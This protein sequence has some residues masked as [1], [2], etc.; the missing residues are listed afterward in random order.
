MLLLIDLIRP[1]FSPFLSELFLRHQS[2]L[3]FEAGLKVVIEDA[4]GR[5]VCFF[6][7]GFVDRQ[8]EG[9]VVWILFHL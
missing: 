6:W 4:V 1:L 7:E 5:V 2:S 3:F 8:P 9:F